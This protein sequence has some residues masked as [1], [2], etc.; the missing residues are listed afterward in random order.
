MLNLK[1]VIPLL[2]R[3]PFH[4]LLLPVFFMLS[5]YLQYAGLLD[6]G[7]MFVAFLKIIAALLAG[8]FIFLFFYRDKQKAAMLTTL[9]GT[10]ALFFGNI[11]EAM[12]K[13]PVLQ[14]AS[15]YRI[16]LPLLLILSI[17][18]LIKTK[19]TANC[20]MATFF[21]NILF[22]IYVAIDVSRWTFMSS[23]KTD[24][25][26]Y[27]Q[28]IASPAANFNRDIYYIV[29]DGYPS[30]RY[31][32]EV[33]GV[34]GNRLDSFL[35]T[36]GFFLVNNSRSNYNNTAF[37]MAA[38][39][40]MQY[41]A[42]LDK[43]QYALPH[44]Y[45]EAVKQVRDASVF[46]VFEQSGYN[47]INLSVFDLPGQ[48][49]VQKERFL[50]ATTTDII[51][52]HTLWHHLKWAIIP[53]LFRTYQANVTEW[54][55]QRTMKNLEKFR[56]YNKKVVDSLFKLSS[57]AKKEPKFVYAHL[58]MPHFPYFYDASGQPY[59]NELVYSDS[60]INHRDRFRNYIEYTNRTLTALI[61]SIFRQNAGQDIIVVQSDHGINDI[62]GSAKTDIFRNYCAIYFPDTNYQHLYPELST[63]NTFRIIFNKYFGQQLTLL[64]DT[65]IYIK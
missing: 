34:P 57:S 24:V 35:K 53:S 54:H 31:Q 40:N 22:L 33:L 41:L 49:A 43:V 47:I 44:H 48:P 28:L 55:R 25:P 63:V 14:Y 61:D 15:Q 56:A 17:F 9:A 51:F 4:I 59:P 38:S 36:K 27:N 7:E 45:N 60:M 32:A 11:K 30:S 3:Q 37:S 23:D 64:K 12:G 20:S 13:L 29:P 1:K 42:S 16:L 62:P 6:T 39:L 58:E 5:I 50:S 46:R 65:S 2:K 18:I 10:L 52:Y 21:L 26:E 8:F 19:K